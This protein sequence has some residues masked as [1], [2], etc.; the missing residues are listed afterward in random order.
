MITLG[1]GEAIPHRREPAPA[2]LQALSEAVAW[3]LNRSLQCDRLRSS[4]LDPATFLIVPPL[5]EVGIALWL[6]NKRDS[7]QRAASAVIEK[8]S[9]LVRDIHLADADLV[10]A[11]SKG[12]LL[13]YEPQETVTDGAAAASS[14]GFFDIKDAPPWDTWFLYSRD[15][16]LSWVPELLV[17]DV[18]DG[19]DANPVSCIYWC[20]WSKLSDF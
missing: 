4:Q 2:V 16:I 11:Q 19:I 18:Q 12:K 5:E 3:C 15:T 8:R 1:L 9:A 7:Y 13:V 20:D 14:N 10:Q 6:E 17:Q